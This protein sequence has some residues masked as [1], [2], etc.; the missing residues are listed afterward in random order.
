MW[1]QSTTIYYNHCNLQLTLMCSRR[2]DSEPSEV[3]G[4]VAWEG[5][6]HHVCPQVLL[7]PVMISH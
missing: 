4:L 1:L 6:H 7:V 2:K 3:A 5:E